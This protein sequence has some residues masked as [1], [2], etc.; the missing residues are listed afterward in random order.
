MPC[1]LRG[2]FPADQFDSNSWLFDPSTN[3]D[4]HDKSCSEFGHFVTLNSCVFRPSI[5][6]LLIDTVCSGVKRKISNAELVN[7]D[8]CG[9]VGEGKFPAD[10]NLS[11]AE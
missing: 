9:K 6:R 11:N 4:N 1:Q 10:I 7:F 5:L 2:P 8:L 3:L